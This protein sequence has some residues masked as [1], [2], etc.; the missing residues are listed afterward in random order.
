MRSRHA[1]V[2]LTFSSVI[3]AALLASSSSGQPP[4]QAQNL[5]AAAQTQNL[6]VANQT[7]NTIREFSPTG[8]DLGDFAT[9]GLNG[10][11]RPGL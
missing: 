6:F 8:V 3:A 2:W 1:L 10:P 7:I 11:T 5:F 4:A 9:T